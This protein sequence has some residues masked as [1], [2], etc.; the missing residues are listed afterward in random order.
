MEKQKQKMEIKDGY[1]VIN[2]LK[3][4]G[5]RL[6]TKEEVYQLPKH[7]LNFM[8]GKDWWFD[9]GEKGYYYISSNHNGKYTPRKGDY[10]RNVWLRPV[11]DL[12]SVDGCPVKIG[13]TFQFGSNTYE[14][15]SSSYA[16]CITYNYIY[17]LSCYCDLELKL[18]DWYKDELTRVI[19]AHK[20]LIDETVNLENG[21]TITSAT[22]ITDTDFFLD[23]YHFTDFDNNNKTW[24]IISN[25]NSNSRATAIGETWYYI[26]KTKCTDLGIDK[27]YVDDVLSIRPAL[28]IQNL[29]QSELKIGSIFQFGRR[30]FKIIQKD[31]AICMT[32][33]GK[34]VFNRDPEGLNVGEYDNSLIK[35]KVDNWYT[36]T[37]KK[38]YPK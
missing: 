20:K 34:S 3:I 24:W 21:I 27:F 31:K 18:K 7:L 12:E 2:G 22:L 37:V 19:C 23:R 17:T 30:K 9:A 25:S 8:Y 28:N 5:A 16:V 14:I 6:M 10:Y 1:V 36:R 33:I 32:T 38:Y 4:C 26:K 11:L 35:E 15:A 13:D 29:E